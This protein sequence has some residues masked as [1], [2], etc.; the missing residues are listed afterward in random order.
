MQE[1][2]HIEALW[3]KHTVDVSISADEMLKQAKKDVSGMRTR[4]L[5]NIAGMILSF[6]AF[7][8]L[9]LFFDFQ[10]LTTHIGISIIIIT[11]AVYIV[12]L[13]NNYRIISNSDFTANPN[14]FIKSLKLYQLNRFSL[15]NRLYWFYA[16]ALSLGMVLYFFEV[17]GHMSPWAQILTVVLSFGWMI[18]CSTLVRKAVIKRDRERISLLIEKFERISGQFHENESDHLTP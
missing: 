9:W 2:D 14:E 16:I 17:F 15:H 6:L 13:Y 5:L 18:F 4:S 7:A 1:F 3:A 8:A 10:S 11:V 12:I